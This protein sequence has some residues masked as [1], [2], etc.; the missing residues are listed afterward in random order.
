MRSTETGEPQLVL[1][2]I[3]TISTPV[4]PVVKADRSA[5][6][7]ADKIDGILAHKGPSNDGLNL[8]ATA[9]PDFYTK[10]KNSGTDTFFADIQVLRRAM[11]RLRLDSSREASGL[12]F[13]PDEDELSGVGVEVKYSNQQ[14]SKFS[15]SS[16]VR[17]Y[18]W[19]K[20]GTQQYD[21]SGVPI[22]VNA[23]LVAENSGN[24][25]ESEDSGNAT[26][27][28][29]GKRVDGTWQFAD[30]GGMQFLSTENMLID[31]QP[32]RLW[33]YFVSSE[34]TVTTF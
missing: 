33:V 10:G 7:L 4:G 24:G 34:E 13:R 25:L 14:F 21:Q 30:G 26:L 16:D 15:Y 23:V 22:Y 5:T 17:K 8:D 29:S 11:Q 27:L 1:E 19:S 18:Q 32:F 31:L 2:F 20:D 9:N 6:V 3:D 12:A 28:V